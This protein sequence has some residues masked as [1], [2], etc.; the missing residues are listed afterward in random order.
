MF[1]VVVYYFT[2][3]ETLQDCVPMEEAVFKVKKYW[4]EG[5]RLV[6]LTDKDIHVYLPTDKYTQIIPIDKEKTIQEEIENARI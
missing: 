2:W 5:N 6:I 1:D 4:T 3:N